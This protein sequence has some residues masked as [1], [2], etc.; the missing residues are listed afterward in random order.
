MKKTKKI[1]LV[2]VRCKA[3][4]SSW[5]TLKRHSKKHL[6]KETMDE[7]RL[8]KEGH[9]PHQTKIGSE[10]KGKNRIIIT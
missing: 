2:C 6:E 7:F 9:I 1:K 4:F 5:E 10:F 8:L 3:E